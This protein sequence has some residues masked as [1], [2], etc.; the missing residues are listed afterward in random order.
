MRPIFEDGFVGT[1][2][3]HQ[4]LA[5]VVGD[6]RPKDVM[7][8]TL[9]H[10]DRVDLDVAQM[11]GCRRRRARTATEGGERIKTLGTEPDVS[12]LRLGER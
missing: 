3:L 12:R 2:R 8:A 9:D 7:M 1:L 5:L 11:R 10:V 6:A 4:M